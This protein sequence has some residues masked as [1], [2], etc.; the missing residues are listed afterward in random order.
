MVTG[1]LRRP[2]TRTL[3]GFLLGFG[4]VAG[5]ELVI[6][7]AGLAAPDG[8]FWLLAP[9]SAGGLMAW[10][11]P[12][13]DKVRFGR[14]RGRPDPAGSGLAVLERY[15]FALAEAAAERSSDGRRH[16]LIAA[17]LGLEGELAQVPPAMLEAGLKRGAVRAHA[18]GESWE[19]WAMAD[20][21][22]VRK[23]ITTRQVIRE[24]RNNDR[25]SRA[26]ASSPSPASAASPEAG[27]DLVRALPTPIAQDDASPPEV[28]VAARPART[29][30]KPPADV[31]DAVE[32]TA[33][34]GA[35]DRPAKPPRRSGARKPRQTTH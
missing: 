17:L 25:R 4:L 29:R 11:F 35:K 28:L 27:S 20:T 16:A 15:V 34:A 5:L 3:V 22:L 10:L 18:R 21:L 7:S 30:R 26:A 19:R 8:P 31:V 14:S 12:R 24:R 13:L 9:V 23:G 2:S 1:M 6:L 33:E 32:G